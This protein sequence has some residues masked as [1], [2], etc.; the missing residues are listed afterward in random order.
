MSP[1]VIHHSCSP[2]SLSSSN[3]SEAISRIPNFLFSPLFPVFSASF[4]ITGLEAPSE[5]DTL[6]QWLKMVVVVTISIS[7]VCGLSTRGGRRTCWEVTLDW[8]TWWWG[9]AWGWGRSWRW[10][11]CWCWCLWR[12]ARRR[13]SGFLS[14]RRLQRR[15]VRQ[16]QEMEGALLWRVGRRV[17]LRGYRQP[18]WKSHLHLVLLLLLCLLPHLL[19]LLF[20]LLLLLLHLLLRESHI[21]VR[22]GVS[23]RLDIGSFVVC[24]VE[25]HF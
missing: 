8:L 5:A 3:S 4:W 2:T 9:W 16:H 18:C 21:R 10:R 1:T 15:R 12:A 13:R 19:L 24:L 17:V 20:C 7:K 23:C 6:T 25:H 22:R 14:G 11:S